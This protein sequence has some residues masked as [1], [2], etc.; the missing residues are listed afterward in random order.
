MPFM[1][2]YDPTFLLLIPAMIFAFWAQW[3]VQ[4]TYARYSK[5]RASAGITGAEMARAIMNRNGIQDVAIEGVEGM[6]SDHYDPRTR[7]VCLSEPIGRGA[8]ISSIAVAAHEVGHAM[9]HAQGYSPLALRSA[10]APVVGF[11]SMAA[12]P[13]FMIG[14]FFRIPGVSGWLMD[15]GILFFA[16]AVVFHLV[17]LPVEF[18]ASKRALV[19]LTQHGAIAPEEVSGAKKVLDA[20][21]LTYVAAAAM[22]AIQLLRLLILRDN[23]R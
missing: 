11:A 18:D 3:R 16:G 7:K 5:V 10:M 22:A 4:N 6:L 2:G 15:L 17:T 14:L 13:L 23:R 20:A 1:M 19:Q 8:S 21:A 9:Q 12:M